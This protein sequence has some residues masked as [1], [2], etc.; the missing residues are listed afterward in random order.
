MDIVF[1][2]TC[3][4]GAYLDILLA[5][6]RTVRAYCERHGFEYEAFVGLR[7]GYWPWHASFNRIY[8]LQ[9]LVERGRHDWAVYLDADAYVADLG[10]DLRAFLAD[11][12]DAAAVMTPSGATDAAWDV[13]DGVM[14]L[15]LRHPFTARLLASWR[16]AFE[17]TP[18]ETLRR[19]TG[20]SNPDDQEM[21]QAFLRDDPDAE[22]W[23]RLA[24]R[25]LMNSAYASFVRQFVRALFPDPASRLR[26]IRA[27]VEGVLGERE[28]CELADAAAATA[29]ID[30]MYLAILRRH[31]DPHGLAH[32]TPLVRQ[33][34]FEAG[35]KLIL[36]QMLSSDEFKSRELVVPAPAP[37]PLPARR[38][39]A[40]G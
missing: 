31:A 19:Q 5:T 35:A 10:F 40:R 9:E 13:N 11:K 28:A 16:A 30:K 22:Q 12:A 23:V 32:F 1:T 38:G 33:L 18:D 36:E 20:W 14:L 17:A 24:P 15:N 27:Q 25:E 3:D 29:F 37:A 4:A 7:R 6:S 21:L 26:A 8:L 34:G 2:Q 39:W